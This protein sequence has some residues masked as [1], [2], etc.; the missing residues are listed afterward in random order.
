MKAALWMLAASASFALMSMF[1]KLG[2]AHF[3]IAELVLY[4]SLLGV[5]VM[6]VLLARHG[7]GVSTKRIGM[8]AHRGASGFVSLFMYFHAVA[9]LPLATAVT[10][11]YTAP[12]FLTLLML[13]LVRER[14]SATIIATVG[15]GF[16]GVGLLLQPTL[17]RERALDGLIA[18]GSGAV[19]AIAYLNVSRLVEDGEP[20]E[21]VV[22]YFSLFSLIGALVWMIP[23]TFR[24]PTMQSWWSLAGVA[25]A[26][27]AGQLF[28]TYA[29]G[30]GHPLVAAALSYSTVVFSSVLGI[31]LWN[32]TLT[33]Q[34]WLGIALIIAA[35]IAAV[36]STSRETGRPA[37]PATND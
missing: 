25:V 14:P 10:L 17:A 31:A 29:F 9:A 35:G 4:R 22:F 19:A 20:E 26:G 16:L 34:S 21:R 30:R 8:H 1:I 24:M 12:V 18:L 13:W 32:D 3:S 33:L 36:R 7:V 28:M 23:Q 2:A 6:W 15:A 27:T 11:S 5:A 37:N